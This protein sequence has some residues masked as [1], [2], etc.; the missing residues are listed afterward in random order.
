MS[1]FFKFALGLR[2]TL[3]RILCGECSL[4]P[5]K[6]SFSLLYFSRPEFLY[7]PGC[8]HS[9]CP[10]RAP[11]GLSEGALVSEIVFFFLPW[12]HHGGEALSFYQKHRNNWPTYHLFHDNVPLYLLQGKKSH[13]LYLNCKEG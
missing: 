4:R 6:S 8:S 5:I 10:P 12:D 7:F 13:F 2:R 9:C 1:I 3:T 11:G